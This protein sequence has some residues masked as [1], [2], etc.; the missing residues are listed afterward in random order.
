MQCTGFF[1]ISFR[2]QS[3]QYKPVFCSFIVWPYTMLE[4]DGEGDADNAKDFA[5]F[6]A[7]E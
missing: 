6:L 4:N 5:G 2:R 7:F 3:N 1:V